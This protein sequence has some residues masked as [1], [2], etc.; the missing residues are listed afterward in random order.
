MGLFGKKKEPEPG[1][2]EPDEEQPEEEKEEPEEPKNENIS[3]GQLKADLDKLSAKFTSFYE[4]QK[5]NTER[6]TTINEQVGELRTMMIQRDKDAQSLEARATQAI[7][8]VGTVQP[9]KLMIELQK[10]DG[11]IILLTTGIFMVEIF[12]GY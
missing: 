3:L 10:E 7:D 2:E 12:K 5:S 6:F 1:E 11:K 8:L 9:D 4:L